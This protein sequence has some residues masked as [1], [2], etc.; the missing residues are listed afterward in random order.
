MSHS[1]RI[2]SNSQ[3]IRTETIGDTPGLADLAAD[4]LSR[5]ERVLDS[6]HS[7]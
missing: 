2:T 4:A 6:G 5:A 7:V 3:L 1:R